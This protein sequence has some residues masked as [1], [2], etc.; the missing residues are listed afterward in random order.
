MSHEKPQSI[1]TICRRE[2]RRKKSQ[3]WK[4]KFQTICHSK[5]QIF[6]PN[7]DSPQIHWPPF[8]FA[9]QPFSCPL[10]STPRQK[11]NPSNKFLPPP[12]TQLKSQTPN[13]QKKNPPCKRTKKDGCPPTSPPRC[14][15]THLAGF[16]Q[17]TISFSQKTE[18]RNE[19][20][21]RGGRG[22][23]HSRVP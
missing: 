8:Q 11:K 4:P 6:S 13:V 12:P 16:Q 14:A 10:S 21:P 17:I 20:P 1:L 22:G 23:G 5:V 3:S 9:G 19:I 7:V 18:P 15:C 2:K